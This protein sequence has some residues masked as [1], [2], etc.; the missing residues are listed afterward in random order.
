[1]KI[2]VSVVCE[3]FKRDKIRIGRDPYVP[4]VRCDN[5]RDVRSVA[6]AIRGLGGIGS[7]GGKISRGY[8]AVR[9]IAMSLANPGVENSSS[10][11]LS[12]DV[13]LRSR[14]L[15]SDQKTRL[16]QARPPHG[17]RTLFQEDSSTY[18]SGPAF[19]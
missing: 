12:A 17:F 14:L 16:G 18:G 15:D 5:T 7:A 1:M 6:L 19:H 10:Q 4:A 8:H 13:E 3:D 11:A 9:E 2:T